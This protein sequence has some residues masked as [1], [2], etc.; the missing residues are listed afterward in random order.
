MRCAGLLLDVGIDTET[1]FANLYLKDFSSFKFES[2]VYKKMKLTK[3]GVAYI[4]VD[5]RMQKKFGLSSEDASATV[6]MLDAIK[7]SIIWLALI[8]NEDGSIRV[9]LRSRFVTINHIAEKYHGGGHAC[10]SGATVYSKA[11][12]KALIADLDKLSHDYKETAEGW[13]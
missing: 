1:L 12:L 8:D 5:K 7:G 6:S 3:N 2:Y 9:R 10:A 13:L 4:H 11:E